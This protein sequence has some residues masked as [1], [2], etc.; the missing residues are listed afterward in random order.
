[1]DNRFGEDVGISVVSARIG[2]PCA[3]KI[4]LIGAH[5]GPMSRLALDWRQLTCERI[6]RSYRI[7][8]CWRKAG[9]RFDLSHVRKSWLTSRDQP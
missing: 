9:D 8:W 2:E 5:P 7:S 1:M 6:R 3:G 4:K